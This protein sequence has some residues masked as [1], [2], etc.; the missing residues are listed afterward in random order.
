MTKL[1]L[2]KWTGFYVRKKWR[3]FCDVQCRVT[4][5]QA[6]FRVWHK[7][8]L[9]MMHTMTLQKCWWRRGILGRSIGLP[10]CQSFKSTLLAIESMFFV[11]FRPT[12]LPKKFFL[13]FKAKPILILI[14]LMAF[15]YVNLFLIMKGSL[16]N[17]K[18]FAIQVVFKV[19]MLCSV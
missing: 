3:N 1:W 11:I 15:F 2:L 19:I 6:H 10:S 9:L 16:Y 7:L 5:W 17:I 18:I 13:T 12:I 4:Y 14:I 8:I